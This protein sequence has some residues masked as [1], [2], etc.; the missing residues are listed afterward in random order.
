MNDYLVLSQRYS[1]YWLFFLET[2]TFKLSFRSI[3]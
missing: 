2:M 1:T 3:C